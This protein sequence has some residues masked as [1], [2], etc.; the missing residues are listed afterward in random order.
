MHATPQ[1]FVRLARGML[2]DRPD[3]AR[4][5]L[6]LRRRRR[7]LRRAVR[8]AHQE[9]VYGSPLSGF[10]FRPPL[11][12][13]GCDSLIVV[14]AEG[15]ALLG[16]PVAFELDGRGRHR[17]T[18]VARALRGLQGELGRAATV[19]ELLGYYRAYMAACPRLLASHP[20]LKWAKLPRLLERNRQQLEAAEQQM[21]ACTHA[22]D[23]QATVAN[24]VTASIAWE[25]SRFMAFV[26]RASLD[27][28]LTEIDSMPAVAVGYSAG[29]GFRVNARA[30]A[31][32]WGRGEGVAVVC[33]ADLCSLL[34]AGAGD[35]P[36]GVE[37]LPD[38]W[39][40]WPA[41]RDQHAPAKTFRYYEA[42]EQ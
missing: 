33:L 34:D 22:K 24:A 11:S 3:L 30:I 16:V 8:R 4:R 31:T 35:G 6:A 36:V 7:V 1:F 14:K 2:R 15:L 42:G 29:G 39:R 19:D 26:D 17:G 32:L 23:Q 9:A 20:N 27:A 41:G 21:L 40:G 13:A 25:T 10:G 12:V 5:Y 37:C 38:T 28:V 18:T